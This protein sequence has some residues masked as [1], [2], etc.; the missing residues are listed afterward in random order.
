M[1][2][3]LLFS[4]FL[5]NVFS[6]NN[7]NEVVFQEQDKVILKGIYAKLEKEN[8]KSTAELVA[9]VGKTF[10]GTPYVAHTLEGGK[11]QLIVNLRE[12]DCTTYAENCL[13]IARSIKNGRNNFE[14]FTAELQAI[15]YRNGII[16]GYPSRLHY[17]SDWIYENDRKGR[18]KDV[19]KAI[20][21]T[22][23]PLQVDFMSTHPGS[24][25]QLESNPGFVNDLSEKEKEISNR[26]MYYLP[27]QKLSEYEHEL[28]EGDIVGITTSIEGLDITHVGILVEHDGRIHLM[29]ASSAAEKVVISEEPLEDY[30]NAGSKV[31]G[32]MVAR[33]L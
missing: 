30:L 19:S 5:F 13:A 2:V 12:L 33:P 1:K 14:G 21:N 24:Y 6:V 18:I 16:D 28:R 3:I 10:L 11:E 17:F 7:Q 27:K 4:I 15:R 25:K 9:L 29:H 8:K 23:Y 26:Q 32:I 22:P 20:S 31:T